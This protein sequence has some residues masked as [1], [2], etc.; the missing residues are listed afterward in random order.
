MKEKRCSKCKIEKELE[1]FYND[2][3]KKDGKYPQCKECVK[4]YRKKHKEKIKIHDKKFREENKEKLTI[5]AK[6]YREKNT[7]K[8]KKYYKTEKGKIASS[9]ARHKRRFLK[10]KTMDGSIPTNMTCPL[11]K[12]LQS[13]LTKQDNKCYLCNT[14][15][16]NAKHLDHWIPLSKGGRHSID[17]VIWLCPTCNLQKS[18][19]VPNELL[20][21]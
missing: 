1:E 7:E 10:L 15:I 2:K 18:A 8:I 5:Y 9:N 6:Q 14:D 3:V 19:K 16:S 21:I 4:E 12:E 13:L 17:N 20:L 11:T